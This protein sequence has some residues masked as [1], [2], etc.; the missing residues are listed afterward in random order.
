MS[1]ENKTR[2]LIWN[3][4]R[5]F[6]YLA[7]LIAAF[8]LIKKYAPVSSYDWLKPISDRVGLMYVIYTL[9][10]ILFG[11]IPPELFM[12]WASQSGVPTQYAGNIAFLSVISYGAGYLGFWV[13]KYLHHTKFYRWVRRRFLG[14]YVKYIHQFGAFIVL[15]AAATPLPFSG[16]SM[17]V[18]A[19][20]YA[21]SKYLLF[22]SVRFIRYFVYAYF[23]W[24][25]NQV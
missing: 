8:L 16:I 19:V 22:A 1:S 13:G 3:L 5:G 14:K 9:S 6:L 7:V 10:E 23:I 2:F 11:I 15:V 20:D 18:G 21:R 4:L 25:A 12:I 17:L 24:E